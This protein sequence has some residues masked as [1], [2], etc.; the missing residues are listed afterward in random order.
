MINLRD[1]L[2]GEVVSLD[3]AGGILSGQYSLTKES[4]LGIHGTWPKETVLFDDGR[5]QITVDGQEV[6]FIPQTQNVKAHARKSLIRQALED[7]AA[8]IEF[9][10]PDELVSP[11]IPPQL[12][13][14]VESSQLESELSEVLDRGH[15]HFIAKSPRYTMRYD[16]ELLPVSRVKRTASD[17]QRHLAAHSDCWYQRT[18]TGIIPKKLKAKISE[19]EYHIY[20]NRVFAR[21][22]DHMERYFVERLA[23]LRLLSELLSE[24]INFNQNEDLDYRLREAICTVWG[25]SFKSGDAESL[26]GRTAN[27]LAHFDAQLQL[28]RTLKQSETYKRI[29]GNAVVPISLKP[30]N[31]LLNDP[32]YLKLRH[33]W[34]LWVN[35]VAVNSKNPQQEFLNC[36]DELQHYRKYTGL[37]IMRAF[38]ALGWDVS[39]NPDATYDLSHPCGLRGQL[40]LKSGNWE[41]TSK[42]VGFETHLVIVPSLIDGPFDLESKDRIVSLVNGAISKDTI[43]ASPDNLESEELFIEFIQSWAGRL[44]VPW[45]GKEIDKL[46][47]VMTDTWLDRSSTK[48][49]RDVGSIDPTEFEAWLKDFNLSSSVKQAV[50]RSFFAARFI[51]HCPCCSRTVEAGGYEVREGRGFIAECQL[52]AA[53]WQVRSTGSQ[54]LFEIGSSIDGSV[55]AGRWKTV[56]HL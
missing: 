24:G 31:I 25:E 50:E 37:L 18:F 39:A 5:G 36:Q 13:K 43:L 54:W 15:L 45:Y 28:I 3:P 35:E 20:E 27:Q 10:E 33:L 47:T 51:H 9:Q 4:D 42:A 29:P 11:V 2:S 44:V 19:D 48:T 41:L 53:E 1:C 21:F 56:S 30:T 22:L 52:C 6:A 14:V 46:P 32:H 16:E 17:Y 38:K 26:R 40:E 12:A 55:K 8:L 34:E 23:K 49:F 7:L